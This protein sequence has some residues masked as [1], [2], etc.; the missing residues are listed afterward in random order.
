[1]TQIPVTKAIASLIDIATTS[2]VSV[3]MVTKEYS[4]M[5][6]F[7]FIHIFHLFCNGF[8]GVKWK[9]V[10]PSSFVEDACTFTVATPNTVT[11]EMTKSE[12]LLATF[13]FEF[14]NIQWEA[15]VV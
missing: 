5:V 8:I 7:L 10:T 1:M 13:N 14:L 15:S 6:T 4:V 11:M 12:I 9:K 2:R 3:A